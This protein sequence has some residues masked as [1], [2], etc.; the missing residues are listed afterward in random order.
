MQTRSEIKKRVINV[1][2][3]QL[4]LE[5]CVPVTIG[6][7]FREDLEADSLD[8]V[9][10]VMALEDEFEILI[11][12]EQAEKLVK[13]EDAVNLVCGLLNVLVPPPPEPTP[14]E[15]MPLLDDLAKSE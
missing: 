12:D 15:P 10:L 8:D 6:T 2:G 13:V 4:A 9:E 7:R 5:G 11:P 1:I 14:P 3:E